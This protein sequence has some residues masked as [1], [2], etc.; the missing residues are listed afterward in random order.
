MFFSD[1]V[2]ATFEP[3]GLLHFL[4]FFIVGLGVFLIVYYKDA[5]RSWKHE[6]KLAISM[7]SFAQPENIKKRL[8]DSVI[9][10]FIFQ[11]F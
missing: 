8:I 1:T 2:G 11:E 3:F 7:A 4:L 9:N 5:I 6:R 10:I